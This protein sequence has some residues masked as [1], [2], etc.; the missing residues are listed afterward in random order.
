[1]NIKFA[2]HLLPALLLSTAVVAHAEP[3]KTVI[4][5]RNVTHQAD[6]PGEPEDRVVEKIPVTYL[7]V[8]TAPVG[9]AL[10]SQLGLPN[11]TGLVVVQVALDSPASSIL[12]EHDVLTKFGDQILID[13]H[14][15]SVLVRAKKEGEEVALTVYRGGKETT[16]KAKLG[17]REIPKVADN[18]FEY[19]MGPGQ[20]FKISGIPGG[21]DTVEL[22][23]LP[24]MGR[25]D[26]DDVLRLIG[27]ERGH[28]FAAPPVHVMR[29]EGG[30]GSTIL[31]LAQGNFVFSDD[32]G[33]VEVNA[34][35]GKRELTVKNKKGDVTFKGPI[36]N[37]GDRKKLPPEVV[38]RLNQI[39]NVDM[40]F[41]PGEDFQQEGAAVPPPQKTKIAAPGQPAHA[42]PPGFR[43]L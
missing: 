4:V 22:R 3:K 32:D 26:V 39:E 27:R 20:G 9:R 8:V 12:K 43:R 36:N 19:S 21:P 15:L 10:A 42:L 7:G 38:A 35:D 5:E 29:R 31:D 2:S 16:V 14:Q 18:F 41:Q 25:E 33:S 34:D 28:W 17:K 23:K 24:G 13:Q 40:S 1:M 37:D 30:Q 6:G 11:D